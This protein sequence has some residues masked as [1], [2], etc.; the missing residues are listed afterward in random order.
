MSNSI[1][2]IS[3]SDARFPNGTTPGVDPNELA[4][5][6]GAGK[7]LSHPDDSSTP[8]VLE[9]D[10][11][12]KPDLDQP[13]DLENDEDAIAIEGRS[14]AGETMPALSPDELQMILRYFPEAH[15][16]A[17]H[18]Y[19]QDRSTKKVDPSALGARVDLRG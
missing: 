9:V 18:Y 14:R 4:P 15:A 10:S 5:A 6:Q 3:P 13:L 16:S 19:Q 12:E 7:V 17:M 2:P 8:N 1:Q 11:T